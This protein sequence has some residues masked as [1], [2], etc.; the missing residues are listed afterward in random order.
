MLIQFEEFSNI[1]KTLLEA[2]TLLDREFHLKMH[3]IIMRFRPLQEIAKRPVSVLFAYVTINLLR[4]V[5]NKATCWVVFPL[6]QIYI[7]FSCVFLS[8]F[9]RTLLVKVYRCLHCEELDSINLLRTLCT[10]SFG[11]CQ[12]FSS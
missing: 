2:P 8:A 9:F 12:P 7:K 5:C 1:L 6:G 4:S 11:K 10:V 3:R